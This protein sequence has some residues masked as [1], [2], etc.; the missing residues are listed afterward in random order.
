MF[1]DM[2]IAALITH[3][4]HDNMHLFSCHPASDVLRTFLQEVASAAPTLPF[5]YYHV[6]SV[7]GVN[8][9]A[10]WD[11]DISNH[12]NFYMSFIMWG[13][14]WGFFFP[15]CFISSVNVRELIEGIEK[16]I[17]S[18]RGVKFTGSDLMDL[19]QCISYIPP[20]WSV[21]Y[22]IDEVSLSSFCSM[23]SL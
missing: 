1:L 17:P 11:L 20:H 9:E 4:I 18:F 10:V 16:V 7:T 22:G 12:L 23:L 3:F 19:G 15:V 13:F 6:P 14:F 2:H 5:Y 21:L 8:G